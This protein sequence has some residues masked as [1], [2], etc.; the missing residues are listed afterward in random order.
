MQ[1]LH[2]PNLLSL[3]MNWLL[4]ASPRTSAQTQTQWK[5]RLKTRESNT[6]HYFTIEKSRRIQQP[7]GRKGGREWWWHCS[8]SEGCMKTD[9]RLSGSTCS[10][11]G[12]APEK[13][14]TRGCNSMQCNAKQGCF[15]A[16]IH[17]RSNAHAACGVCMEAPDCW[18]LNCHER[19]EC[20]YCCFCCC[21]QTASI[22]SRLGIH[23]SAF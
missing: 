23:A 2:V 10:S 14:R 6:E 21:C 16:V 20:C 12:G 9:T 7:G 3:R 15:E 22:V 11:G 1:C 13:G 4:R 19:Y 18:S 8:H 5:I 17:R